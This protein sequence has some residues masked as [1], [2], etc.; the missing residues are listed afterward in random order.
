VA[1]RTRK[2]DVLD[3]KV[4]AALN[5]LYAKTP[6]NSRRAGRQSEHSWKAVASGLGFNVGYIYRVAHG[7]RASNRLLHA[8]GLPM[9]TV[10]VVVCP[11]CGEPPLAKHHRCANAIPKLQRPRRN[12]KGLA[13]LLTGLIANRKRVID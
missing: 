4:E 3:G 2:K 1:M 7:K 11:L 13:L 12:W 5:R 9:R 8:L 10:P 6:K